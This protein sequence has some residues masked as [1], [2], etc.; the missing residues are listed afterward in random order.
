MKPPELDKNKLTLL[1]RRTLERSIALFRSN[2]VQT[3]DEFLDG[4][5]PRKNHTL[6]IIAG[7]LFLVSL[8]T[9]I[10]R[11]FY[12]DRLSTQKTNTILADVYSGKATTVASALDEIIAEP[13]AEKE[14]TANTLRFNEKSCSFKL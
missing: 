11:G 12:S 2:R 7:S 14:V 1:Q 6:G 4:M 9:V 13:G 10:T 5:R 3:I 8:I